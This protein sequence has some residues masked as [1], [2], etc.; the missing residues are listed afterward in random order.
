MPGL[1]NIPSQFPIV[2]E[3]TSKTNQTCHVTHAEINRGDTFWRV[4]LENGQMFTISKT[5]TNNK[6]QAGMIAQQ[7]FG[8]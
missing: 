5:V 8:D 2:A 1:N 6:Q 3:Y 4:Q 7:M